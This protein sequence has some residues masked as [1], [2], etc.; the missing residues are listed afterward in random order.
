MDSSWLWKEAWSSEDWKQGSPG[1]FLPELQN[2]WVPRGLSEGRLFPSRVRVDFGLLSAHWRSAEGGLSLLWPGPLLETV[3]DAA[4]TCWKLGVAGISAR[5][6]V[7]LGPRGLSDIP[8]V[9]LIISVQPRGS[10]PLCK[11][12]GMLSWGSGGLNGG[13]RGEVFTYGVSGD[14]GNAGVRHIGDS[15]LFGILPSITSRSGG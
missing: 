2:S 9:W 4:N 10:R 3:Q 13:Y 14:T 7:G 5:S 15:L 12:A 11:L 6:R 1:E 8:T